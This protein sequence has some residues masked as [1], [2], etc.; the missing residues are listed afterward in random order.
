MISLNHL[1]RS[2]FIVYVYDF[3]FAQFKLIQV[4]DTFSVLELLLISTHNPPIAAEPPHS[5]T[6]GIL[7]K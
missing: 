2:C 1:H 4:T 5:Q 6:Q 3:V 7:K